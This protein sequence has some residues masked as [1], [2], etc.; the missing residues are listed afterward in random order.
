MSDIDGRPLLGF[1]YGTRLI[2]VAVGQ[3]ITGTARPLCTVKN[4]REGEDWR[5]L[6]ALVAEWQPAALVV[7]LPLT[8]DGGEQTMSRKARAFAGSLNERYA[9]PTHMMD[10]RMSSIESRQRFAEGR[11]QGLRRKRDAADIDAIAAQ[12]ILENWLATA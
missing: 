9:L 7:G 2:G 4:S 12:I 3:R 1:D 11:R 8:S 5:R 10:E 6:D